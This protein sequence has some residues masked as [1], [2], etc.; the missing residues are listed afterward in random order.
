MSLFPAFFVVAL[1]KLSCL[2]A[3]SSV[4]M[5]ALPR[6]VNL[7]HSGMFSLSGSPV[8]L[9]IVNGAG[10]TPADHGPLRVEKIEEGRPHRVEYGE[11]LS[12]F[13]AT[14]RVCS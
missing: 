5:V 12:V 1:V 14:T 3:Q 11:G 7:E 8:L 10:D 9:G 4:S 13:L 2:G 6:G